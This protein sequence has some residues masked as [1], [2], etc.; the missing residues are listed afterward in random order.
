MNGESRN[1]GNNTIT[2]YIFLPNTTGF[3]Y[4]TIATTTNT[5]QLKFEPGHTESLFFENS[6]ST[7]AVALERIS[8]LIS[9]CSAPQSGL[10]Q[11][12]FPPWL[13]GKKLPLESVGAPCP[14]FV[15][16]RVPFPHVGHISPDLSLGKIL[17]TD[18]N[19]GL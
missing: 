18:E 13:S 16:S 2:E 8:A 19:H 6:V 4:I 9:G 12:S 15:G 7:C 5:C 10:V 1:R 11:I 14:T 17:Q 3:L